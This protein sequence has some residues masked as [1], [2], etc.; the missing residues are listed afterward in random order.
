M[1]LRGVAENYCHLGKVLE[2]RASPASLGD[3][4]F[5]GPALFIRGG[6]SD[7]INASDEVEIRQLFPA[8]EIRTIATANHW[9]H[10]DAPEE[11]VRLV[12]EF[13]PARA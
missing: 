13:I 9:V 2:R 11:F 12:L 4:G 1:N 10:A 7:Y 5:S 3:G 6:K 8:V